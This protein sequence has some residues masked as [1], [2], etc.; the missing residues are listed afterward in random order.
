M[1]INNKLYSMYKKVKEQ[2]QSFSVA[3]RV[4]NGLMFDTKQ[5][6]DIAYSVLKQFGIDCT[7][8]DKFINFDIIF[9][10]QK[11]IMVLYHSN[12]F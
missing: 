7:Q 6:A 12:K 11:A 10:R 2:Y 4:G 5:N 3:D 9:T 1:K 8:S